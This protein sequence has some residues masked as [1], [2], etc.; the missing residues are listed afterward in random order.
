M[1]HREKIKV[2]QDKSEKSG[3]RQLCRGLDPEKIQYHHFKT[4]MLSI[5]QHYWLCGDICRLV[6]VGNYADIT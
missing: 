2:I 5:G 6:A 3:G 1:P 4:R